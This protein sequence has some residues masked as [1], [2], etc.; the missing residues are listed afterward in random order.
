MKRSIILI[1][2][3]FVLA[4]AGCAGMRSDRA[5]QKNK[6]NFI[7][8]IATD[9][10]QM[11]LRIDR[12]IDATETF[13]EDAELNAQ[14]VEFVREKNNAGRKL[15]YL[16]SATPAAWPYMKAGMEEAML[17]LELLLKEIGQSVSLTYEG[18]SR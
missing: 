7:R 10:G 4:L 6:E 9:L 2:L 1:Q 17:D 14:I 13:H 12:L 15:E 16:P 5:F 11:D 8:M 3:G 18:Q